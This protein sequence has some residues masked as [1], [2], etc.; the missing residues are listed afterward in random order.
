MK[1]RF[2]ISLVV[3]AAACAVGFSE[4]AQA[5]C[6][7]GHGGGYG[8]GSSRG[9]YSEYQGGYDRHYQTPSRH[10]YRDDYE[11]DYRE[12]RYSRVDEYDRREIYDDRTLYSERRIIRVIPDRS[13]VTRAVPETSVTSREVVRERAP[14]V[15]PAARETPATTPTAPRQSTRDSGK[16]P[17]SE[18]PVSPYLN[19]D[20]QSRK[21]KT[22]PTGP[23]E[24]FKLDLPKP[25]PRDQRSEERIPAP[26]IPKAPKTP[27][28]GNAQ[29]SV[30][31]S[32]KFPIDMVIA[33]SDDEFTTIR[34]VIGKNQAVLIDFWASWCG[35]CI[36]SMPV[37]KQ[38]AEGLKDIGVVVAGMNVES[39]VA[40]AKQIQTKHRMDN[41]DWLV[42]PKSMPFSET[43]NI[44]SIPQVLL[45]DSKGT[46]LFQGY[47][48]DEK[49]ETALDQLAANN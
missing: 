20:S 37:L 31:T 4:K 40:V 29:R 3:A 45:V 8:Y 11:C 14:Q 5:Q 35:P 15:A 30:A 36:Q 22:E 44:K 28:A 6:D 38:R 32:Q 46:V 1:T 9:Y 7:F 49:L 39:D 48:S 33:N 18:N 41:V 25:A 21:P 24:T 12:R 10:Y 34:E 42:E 16:S 2:R 47:P 23:I 17:V 13:A 26:P 27:A 19:D 43:F